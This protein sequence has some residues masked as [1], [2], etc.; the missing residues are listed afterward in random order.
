MR[1]TSNPGHNPA[2][3]LGSQ[4]QPRGVRSLHKKTKTER[5]A[6]LDDGASI[7]TMRLVS[8]PLGAVEEVRCFC[9]SRVEV[10]D[11]PD[12][13]LQTGQHLEPLQY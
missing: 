12:L 9:I 3:V 4:D 8:Q 5:R 2:P 13:A 7:V 10:S 1:Q 11:F 6:E